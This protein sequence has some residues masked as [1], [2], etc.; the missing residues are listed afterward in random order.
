MSK[1][2]PRQNANEVSFD[3]FHH[4]DNSH[5]DNLG[6]DTARSVFQVNTVTTK[7]KQTW[8][9][10]SLD[11]KSVQMQWDTGASCSM[12]NLDTYHMLGSPLLMKTNQLHGY[13]NAK[14]RTAGEC[15]VNVTLAGYQQ[16]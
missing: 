13:G 9:T 5:N 7:N 4:Y 3:Q 6:T 16:T 1:Q 10:T 11:S 2:R 8:L 14:I 15:R 12:I